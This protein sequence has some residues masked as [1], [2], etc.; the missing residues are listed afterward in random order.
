MVSTA[1][2]R[3]ISIVEAVKTL[4]DAPVG[5]ET[6]KYSFG[7]LIEDCSAM[8]PDFSI[9]KILAS[10]LFENGSYLEHFEEKCG[11]SER[12]ALY[13]LLQLAQTFDAKNSFKNPSRETAIGEFLRYVRRLKIF[14]EE[15]ALQQL[16]ASMQE[17]D[18]V[19][20]LTIHAAKGLEYKAVFVPY[21]GARYYPK[22]GRGNACPLPEGVTD[23]D[24]K[25]ETVKEEKSLF[26]VAI[27]R[28]RQILCLSHST[29]YGKQPSN[30]SPFL[31]SLAEHLPFAPDGGA[32][33]YSENFQPEPDETTEISSGEN[34]QKPEF[35]LRELEDYEHCPRRYFYQTNLKKEKSADAIYLEFHRALHKTLNFCFDE[36][37]ARRQ[38]SLEKLQ[39]VFRENWTT[40]SH[41]Y[42]PLYLTEAVEILRNAHAGISADPT[43][44]FKKNLR[45]FDLPNG[46]VLFS[47]DFFYESENEAGEKQISF[48]R[49]RNG[50]LRKKESDEPLYQLLHE[51]AK[52]G[53]SEAEVKVR[54]LKTG[55]EISVPRKL[56]RGK[57][58]PAPEK[59]ASLTDAIEGILRRNFPPRPSDR[60][61]NCSYYFV[62]AAPFR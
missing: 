55:D 51:S 12:L 39:A 13:H 24:E 26:F 37:A 59:F 43:G 15:Q 40:V 47:A 19:R 4:A 21:L 20:L 44:N 18:A 35:F 60:C 14:G 22:A 3:Q 62:C 30:A 1:I 36:T 56:K 11:A 34:F 6:T 38:V 50:K 17:T 8:P 45:H 53:G 9:W 41:A 46:R 31:K 5:E 54:S 49:W 23:L 52:A 57:E 27:S 58:I 61:P 29:R 16:P 7:K 10:Y 42:A 28:A 32:S 2:D 25:A 33:W 48:R